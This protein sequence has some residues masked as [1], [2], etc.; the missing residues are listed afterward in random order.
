MDNIIA[1]GSTGVLI[2]V[3]MRATADGQPLTGLAVGA[4]TVSCHRDG[5]AAGVALGAPAV[6]ATLGTWETDAWKETAIA[7]VYQYG[8][9][10]AALIAG[11]YGV[12]FIFTGTSAVTQ[13]YR[14]VFTDALA[15][16]KVAVDHNTG[17][18]DTLRYTTALG[19]AIAD[20]DV[21]A[22]TTAD[23]A[24][25]TFTLRAKT[26]TT[27]TGRWLTPLYLDDG[28]PYTIVFEKSGEY[29][30]NTATVTP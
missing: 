1:A 9:P 4:V 17:G 30:P 20:A 16:D 27:A 21:R 5:A 18:A 2:E 7:G 26:T 29:G 22:Y 10:N 23:Y 14:I 19:V 3:V 25:G 13:E 28:V 24:A 6:L 11:A 8:V 12:T 15:D